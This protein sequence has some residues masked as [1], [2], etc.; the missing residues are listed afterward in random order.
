MLDS[1]IKTLRKTSEYAQGN[2]KVD[3][4]IKSRYENDAIKMELIYLNL[5]FLN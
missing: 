3:E 1:V 2:L 4:E 5:Y